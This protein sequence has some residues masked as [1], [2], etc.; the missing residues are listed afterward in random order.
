MTWDDREDTKPTALELLFTYGGG[1]G[2]NLTYRVVELKTLILEVNVKKNKTWDEAQR[3]LRGHVVS[4]L[5]HGHI[6]SLCM[7][8]YSLTQCRPSQANCV[9]RRGFPP[10]CSTL[11]RHNILKSRSLLPLQWVSF[12]SCQPTSELLDS[13]QAQSVRGAVDMSGKWVEKVLAKAD[14]VLVVDENFNV[15]LV[16]K[17][18]PE[19]VLRYVEEEV[20][21]RRR[22]LST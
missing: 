20:S 15:L 22:S 17:F 3:E 14:E 21:K 13:F 19:D 10:S 5:R 6:L 18:L 16:S 2:G 9:M 1:G 12:A 8:M 7:S 4:A 11:S